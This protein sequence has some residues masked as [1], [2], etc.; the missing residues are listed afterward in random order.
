MIRN[1]T[2]QKLYFYFEKKREIHISCF[3]NRFYNGI[4]LEINQDK[5]YL[6]LV[7]KKLGEVPVMFDEILNV[8]PFLEEEK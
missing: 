7:D 6:I 4:I 2:E 3:A 5:G 8:E 1:E